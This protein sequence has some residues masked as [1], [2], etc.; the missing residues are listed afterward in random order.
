MRI[1]LSLRLIEQS[2]LRRARIAP[3]SC[4]A[5]KA[6]R[7]LRLGTP[8]WI[9]APDPNPQQLHALRGCAFM[10]NLQ[11]LRTHVP[12]RTATA[13]PAAMPPSSFAQAPRPA[14]PSAAPASPRQAHR[15]QPRCS[16]DL[17]ERRRR[18]VGPRGRRRPP[19]AFFA[20]PRSCGR[21]PSSC[22]PPRS[23]FSTS[24]ISVSHRRLISCTLAR[25]ST[26]GDKAA[27]ELLWRCA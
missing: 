24:R 4:A 16:L 11:R 2:V 20:R 5:H 3:L 15:Q 14:P 26:V 21:R 7:R 8:V 9:H 10:R 1:D 27:A 6:R 18:A 17:L 13:A 22:P 19:C 23:S 12:A 25:C